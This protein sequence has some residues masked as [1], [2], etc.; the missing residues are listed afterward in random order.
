MF[1]IYLFLLFLV[2]LVSDQY[3]KMMAVTEL[4]LGETVPVIEG[5]FN[6]TLVHNPG[7]AFGMFSDWEDS[8]RR[9]ALGVVSVLALIVVAWFM[10]HE[11]KD[12]KVAQVALS[13]IIAGAVGNLIDRFRYDYVIDFLDFYWGN[14]HWPAFNIADSAITIGVSILVVIMVFHREAVVEKK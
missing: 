1:K 8:N 10:F 14:Y 4:S 12:D 11:A 9:I 13:A 2:L 5:Y 7:A 3:S 6:F